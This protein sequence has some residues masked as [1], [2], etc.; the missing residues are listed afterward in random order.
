MA[1]FA[2]FRGTE[3]ASGDISQGPSYTE[4]PRNF[5]EMIL[6]ANP[7]GR[8]PLTAL[9]SRARSDSTDDPEFN[10]WEETLQQIRVQMDATGASA[11]STTFGLVSGGLQLVP[12]DQLLVEK[13]DT[14]IF[15][16]EVVVVSSVTDDTTII[17]KRAQGGTTGAA[18]GASAFLT[19]IG[20]VYEEG[21]TSPSI[22]QRTPT[23]YTNRAQIFKTAVGITLTMDK[24][25]LRTGDAWRTDKKRKA[26]DHSVA[27]EYAFIFGPGRS[28]AGNG[29]VTYGF[30]DTTGTF[31]KRFTGGLRTMIQTNRTVFTTTPDENSILDALFPVFD[32]DSAGAG[33]ERIVLAGNGALN[34]L[35]KIANASSSSRINFDGVIDL[36]GMKLQRWITPQ[37][38]FGIRTHP[39]LNT[40]GRYTNSM[41]VINPMG[42][43]YRFLRD[44]TFMDNIQANDEDSRKGQWLTEAGLELNHEETFAYLGNVTFP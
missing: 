19:K 37:G 24:T 31:A 5:R 21:S 27:L 44:T 32:F 9:L 18:T 34:A 8:A 35:N 12:G 17:V 40:H 14:T 7:N 10:W 38:V 20:N 39:L 26:F 41:F 6:W 29:N 22:S 15:D 30:V 33:D 2:G 36:F 4:R 1:S 43:R 23:M 28:V 25:R 3:N 42:L 16:N 13:A 11:T